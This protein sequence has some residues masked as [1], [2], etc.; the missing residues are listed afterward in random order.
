[1]KVIVIGGGAAGMLAAIGAAEYGNEVLLLERNE[2]LGKKIYITGKGR[3]NVTNNCDASDLMKNICRNPKFLYSAFDTFDNT[4][5]QNLLI[6][7]GCELKVER[8]ERVFPVSDHA[9]DVIRALKNKMESLNIKV[10]LKQQVKDIIIEDS[11]VKGI[12]TTDNRRFDSDWVIV[13]V[14]GKSY[15]TTGSDGNFNIILEKIGHTIVEPRPALVGFESD[16]EWIEELA[17][18]ALKNIGIKLTAEGLKKPRYSDFGEMLF[19]HKGISGPVILSAS[20]F[21]EPGD[22]IIIDLKPALDANTLDQR[23]LREFEANS[24]KD[25]SNACDSLF[26]KKLISTMIK[27]SNIPPSTKVHQ[28]TAEQRAAFGRLIKNLPVSISGTGDFSEAIITRG[29]IN[30]K[31]VDPST[32]Q[33]KKV[34]G[35]SFAGEVLD[36]DAVT[37]GFNLQI[38]WSTGYLAGTR[39]GW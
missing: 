31:E 27:L 6:E 8:G 15:P 22:K 4:D 5:I 37:G 11:I 34:N 28:I 9:S 25:F 26:P 39:V 13:C 19:T 2:K 23:L 18:L 21:Y 7:Q 38:A 30:V 29:G 1:M 10:M 32:M 36:L 14:G 3:C 20:S 12:I 17:G 35:L 24:N 16:D 33:S